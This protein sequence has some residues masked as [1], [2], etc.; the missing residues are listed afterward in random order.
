MN[1][2]NQPPKQQPSWI[3][4]AMMLGFIVISYLLL[5]RVAPTEIVYEIPYSEFKALVREQKV[6]EVQLQGEIV[7]GQLFVAEAIGPQDEKATRFRSRMPAFGDGALLLDLEDAGVTVTVSPAR[8]EGVFM[9]LLL[10][11]LP[12][13]LFIGVFV[14]LMSRAART[15]G[16]FGGPKELSGFLEAP[17]KEAEVPEVTF[18]DVAG[19]ENAKREITELVEYLKNPAL[20]PHDDSVWVFGLRARLAL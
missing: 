14:W 15:M 17:A 7:D 19:Q 12:W 13:L 18:A 11:T 3:M 10:A 4:I 5:Y 6:L 9:Q 2:E 8:E 16:R 20:N 1:S